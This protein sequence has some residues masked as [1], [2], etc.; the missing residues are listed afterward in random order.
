MQH[1][2][3]GPMSREHGPPGLVDADPPIGNV[4]AAAEIQAKWSRGRESGHPETL[5][6]SRKHRVTQVVSTAKMRAPASRPHP[7]LLGAPV[8]NRGPQH[9]TTHPAVND[10]A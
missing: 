7:H 6:R 10:L 2:S 5:S 8:R 4:G 1:S 3:S 9:Q